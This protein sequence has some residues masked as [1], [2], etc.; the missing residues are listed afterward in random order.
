MTGGGGRLAPAHDVLW[1]LERD[2][3]LIVCEI[4]R[5]ADDLS[6]YEFEMADSEGPRTLRFESPAELIRK[7]LSEQSKLLADGW[8]PRRVSA[9]D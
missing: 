1:F 3:D 2:N 4:R 6:M 7:Y 9:V 8:R 5:A